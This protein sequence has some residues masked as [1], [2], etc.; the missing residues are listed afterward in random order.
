MWTPLFDDFTSLLEINFAVNEIN[1][2]S[3][4]IKYFRFIE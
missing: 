4:L 2:E 3:I 1:F